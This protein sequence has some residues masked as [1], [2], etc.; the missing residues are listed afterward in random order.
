MQYSTLY[1]CQNKQEG[2]VDAIFNTICMSEQARRQCGCNI[3]H[4][5]YVRASKKAVW[6][7]YSTLYVC[8]NKQEG[9]VDEIFN[10]ICMSEQARRQCGCNI[11]HYMYVRTSKKAVWMQYSTLYVCQNKQEGSVDAIFN[12]ICM[13]EQARRQC[14]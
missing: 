5:M 9:S 2:S 6:M 11:Q 10:T 3:Q 4:Y 12:T 1:V 8:Q 7:Q 13:S 14:G